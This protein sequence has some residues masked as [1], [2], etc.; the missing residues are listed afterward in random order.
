ME[1]K[2]PN[3]LRVWSIWQA[4]DPSKHFHWPAFQAPEP[5][6]LCELGPRHVVFHRLR[7]VCWLLWTPSGAQ[8]GSVRQLH[9]PGLQQG[10]RSHRRDNLRR[11]RV[12]GN[13][14]RL[15]HIQVKGV[16]ICLFWQH[17]R[18]TSCVCRR[19]FMGVFLLNYSQVP[20]ESNDTHKTT[21]S[22]KW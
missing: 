16:N 3:I 15:R 22:W 20:N 13:A 21:N 18:L 1:C 12:P 7:D 17:R 8:P 14:D 10:L 2:F 5:A 19:F 9:L 11:T 4:E 6:P